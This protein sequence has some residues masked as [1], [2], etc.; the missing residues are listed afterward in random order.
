MSYPEKLIRGI[1]IREFIDANGRASASLFQFE[2][3]V[4]ED[5]FHETSISWYDEED[6]LC[7]VMDQKKEDGTIRF[8][9]GAAILLRHWIDE[10]NLRPDTKGFL[11]YERAPLEQNKYHGNL[12]VSDEE[13]TK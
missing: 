6:S 2:D 8:K 13:L 12:F 10:I 4:R 5:G 7:C 9:I 3:K 1:S 11:S